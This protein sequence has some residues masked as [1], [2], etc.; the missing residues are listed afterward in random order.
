MK[1]W[2]TFIRKRFQERWLAFH[3]RVS[4]WPQSSHSLS[5]LQL[6][7]RA[8]TVRQI[9]AATGTYQC[10]VLCHCWTGSQ[11]SFSWL[12]STCFTP[13]PWTV[14]SLLIHFGSLGLLDPGLGSDSLTAL[15]CGNKVFLDPL[16]RTSLAHSCLRNEYWTC[17][18]S[19]PVFCHSLLQQ[20][21]AAGSQML[22]SPKLCIAQA[23][24]KLSSRI[25]TNAFRCGSNFTQSCCL[26]VNDR[27]IQKN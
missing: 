13:G 23:Q 19:K 22:V 20:E 26:G 27:Y 3:R 21:D 7:H 9:C 17:D 14:N 1:P 16:E 12:T 8:P 10:Q 25:V 6:L 18:F 2:P 24:G 5:E 15:S 11:I 4:K